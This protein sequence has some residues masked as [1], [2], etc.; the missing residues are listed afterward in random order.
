MGTRSLQC[1]AQMILEVAVIG[2]GPAGLLSGYYL[3]HLGLDHVIFDKGRLAESWL[4]QRWDSFRMMTSLQRTL[5]PGMPLKSRKPDGYATAGE[6]VAMLHEYVSAHQLP[7]SENSQVIAIERSPNSPVFQL[8]VLQE[9]EVTRT[10]DAWQVIVAAGARSTPVI[11]RIATTLPGDPVQLH[12]SRYRNVEQLAPGT[13]LVVG[14]GQSGLEIAYDLARQGRRVL[15]STQ[16]RVQLPRW[17][18]GREIFEWTTEIAA[19][20]QPLIGYDHDE[21]PVDYATLSSLG[22]VFI[23]P[24]VLAEGRVVHAAGIAADE[25]ARTEAASRDVLQVIDLRMDEQEREALK[26]ET[27]HQADT[28][29]QEREQ[30]G[31]EREFRGFFFPPIGPSVINI[32]REEISTVIWATGF[33]DAFKDIVFPPGFSMTPTHGKGTTSVEG[34]YTVGA[35]VCG[36]VSFVTDLK[37]DASFVTNRI[38][39]ALR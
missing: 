34:I 36:R 7:V 8:K 1:L 38:Y 33:T 19:A 18:R 23:G 21:E 2:A 10:Y 20:D 31:T 35:G 25:I 6:F 3:R 9:G 13:V 12:A 30:E 11:P 16:P 37:D 29:A 14:S 15:L 32:D 5:L 27:G 26:R 22:V 17:Y 39:S 4:T 24:L 28:D